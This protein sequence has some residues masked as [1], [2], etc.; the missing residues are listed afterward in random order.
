MIAATPRYT[1]LRVSL[2]NDSRDTP[3]LMFTR[4]D[5]RTLRACA[6][7]HTRAR[8]H[9]HTHIRTHART[10]THA[11]THARTQTH[12]HTYTHTHTH[13]ERNFRKEV[14]GARSVVLLLWRLCVG[15][16]LTACGISWGFPSDRQRHA[17]IIFDNETNLIVL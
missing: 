9:T 12:T 16:V 15:L 5:A 8:T 14:S 13:Q 11:D 10:H 2:S 3:L 1:E 4:T 7:T 6:H 17:R